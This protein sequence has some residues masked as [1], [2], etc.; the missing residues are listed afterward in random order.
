MLNPSLYDVAFPHGLGLLVVRKSAGTCPCCGRSTMLWVSW[1][2]E[3]ER[4]DTCLGCAEPV[5]AS[6]IGGLL[7]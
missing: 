1:P 6:L 4:R 5:Q 7:P 2:P 3:L